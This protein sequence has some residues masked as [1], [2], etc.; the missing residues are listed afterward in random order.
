MCKGVCFSKP[1]QKP[2][3]LV[4]RILEKNRVG[5]V[6]RLLDANTKLG[7]PV[8][9]RLVPTMEVIAVASPM[10]RRVFKRVNG[11]WQELEKFQNTKCER[12][13]PYFVCINGKDYKINDLIKLAG[14]KMK[15]G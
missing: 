8:S 4:K 7:T 2:K 12:R 10:Y 1:K 6:N 14:Y 9:A 3:S 5:R 13:A 15:K 11:K